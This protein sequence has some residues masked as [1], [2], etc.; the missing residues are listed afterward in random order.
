M[1]AVIFVCSLMY[2]QCL[3][4]DMYVQDTFNIYRMHKCIHLFISLESRD[5][6]VPNRNMFK[7]QAKT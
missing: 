4:C 2:P 5:L 3:Q 1:K 6:E 7:G